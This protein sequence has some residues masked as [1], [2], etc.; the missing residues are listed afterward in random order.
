MELLLYPS[1]VPDVLISSS[2]KLWEVDTFV[3]L[4]L[5]VRQ[6]RHREVNEGALSH[7]ELA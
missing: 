2:Q 4:V 3:I 1:I 6:V 5:R 7:T